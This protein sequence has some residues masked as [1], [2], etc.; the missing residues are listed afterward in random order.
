MTATL[1]WLRRHLPGVVAVVL[2][3]GG[4][5]VVNLP[6][7]SAAE[8]DAMASRYKFV[9]MTIAL[10]ASDKQQTIRKVNKDY[11]KI[12]AWI[13][14]V[15]AAVAMNDLDGD[16]LANDICLVDPRTDQV[17]VTPTPG[18][19]DKRYAPFALDPAPL[20]MNDHIA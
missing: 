2:V 1:G 9:P 19:G 5:F 12:R 4:Y 13:S 14:S 18:K 6:T 7:V 20:P 3:V 17:V 16:G 15:G 10:P 8:Q 11:E